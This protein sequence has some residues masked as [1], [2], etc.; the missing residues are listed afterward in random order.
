[1]TSKSDLNTIDLSAGLIHYLDAGGRGPTVVLLHGVLMNHTVWHGV[2][3]QL[4]P[5]FRCIAPTL[6]LGAHTQPMRPGADL[7]IDGIALL[8]AEFLER[9]ELRDVTLIM[10]DWG[11]PQLLVDHGRIERISRLVLVACEAFDNFPPGTP[12]RRLARLAATPG[13]FGLQSLLLRSAAVRRSV[14]AGLAKHPV[15]DEMLRDW[16][17]PFVQDREIRQNLRS[18]CLS[19]PLDSGRNWSA[20]LASFDKPALVVW[21]PEDQMMPPEHGHRLADLLPQGQLVEITDSYTVVPLDQPQ[22][23]ADAVRVFVTSTANHLG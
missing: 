10:N 11:G 19:V 7:S 6:P 16:F 13:G 22:Q 2:I 4:A 12:G 8:V 23:L 1:M 14:A 20:G 9:L 15:S 3:T 17:G 5:G 21:A 18:Y